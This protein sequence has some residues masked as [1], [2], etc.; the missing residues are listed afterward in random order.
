[1]RTR[2]AAVIAVSAAFAFTSTAPAQQASSYPSKPVRLVVP[3]PP[4]GLNDVVSRL[5][6]QKMG[7]NLGQGVIIENRG[8]ATGTVGSAVVAK[9]P[10]DGYTLLSSGLNTAV[11]GPHLYKNLP[12]DQMKELQPIGRVASINSIVLVH[13]SLPVSSMR[14]LIALAKA[15]PGELNFGSGGAGGSQ[16]VGGELLKALTGIQM[17]H[18]P[19]KGG[20][21][22]MVGLLGGQT[23]IMIEP[24]P[25]ALPQLKSGKVRAL[26]VTTL[27][28]SSVVP[29]LPTVA[30]SGVPGYDMPTWLAWFAPAGTPRDI[31]LKLN[32]ELA[33][34]LR[35]PDTREQLVQRGADPIIDSLE[36][37]DQY[38]RAEFTRWAGVVRDSGMKVE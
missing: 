23:S 16:H 7:E 30:E 26:A 11:L 8:G 2:C 29:H 35:S 24:M 36:E 25:S 27:T 10:A 17:T 18:V 4:G 5:V 20:G 13:P 33:R 1:M 9:A 37:V 21:P 38:V 34:A 6:S 12:Y 14:E 19:Y 3:F 28:R 22:A 15:K 32:G 31:M